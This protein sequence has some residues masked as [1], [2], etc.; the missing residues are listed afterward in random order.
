MT[1]GA[2]NV[3]ARRAERA[4]EAQRRLEEARVAAE[5]AAA[6]RAA[7]ASAGAATAVTRTVPGGLVPGATQHAKSLID[8]KKWRRSA[9]INALLPKG[10]AAMS[11]FPRREEARFG[12]EGES[13]RIRTYK[14]TQVDP[15]TQ[16]QRQCQRQRDKDRDWDR[17]RHGQRHGYRHRRSTHTHR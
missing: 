14:C 2:A 17:D 5:R 12:E 9:V 10:T 4:A 8:K 6:E 1:A 7:E 3:L 13:R 16:R 15:R 11:T